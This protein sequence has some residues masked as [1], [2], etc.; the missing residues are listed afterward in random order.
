MDDR[1]AEAEQDIINL[2]QVINELKA[3]IE[4]SNARLTSKQLECY[5]LREQ[6]TNEPRPHK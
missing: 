6:I 4:T 5:Q 3:Q 2:L 1:L